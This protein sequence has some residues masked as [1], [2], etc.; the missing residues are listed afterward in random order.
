ML[1]A[2]TEF[3]HQTEAVIKPFQDILLGLFFVSV[4]MLLDLRLLLEQLPLVLLLLAV[5]LVVKALIVTLIV[6]QFVHNLR[7]ALR[8]GIVVSMGGEF[9][10]ALL[11]LLLSVGI[12]RDRR[13]CRRCSPRRRSACCS[14]RCSCVTTCASRTAS[15]GARDVVAVDRRTRDGCHARDRAARARDHL[16]LRPCRPEPGARARTPRFRIHRARPRFAS[17]CAMRARP[18]IPSSTATRRIPRCCARS[19]SIRRAWS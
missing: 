10:F 1:L 5:L 6:R 14:G 17:A 11:T 15:C 3:R 19:G 8:T 2:E 18:A 9:G 13:S 12:A 16:R 7:K 4:G